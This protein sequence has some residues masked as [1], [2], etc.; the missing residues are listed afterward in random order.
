M[1]QP[2]LNLKCPF[3][4]NSC[5]VAARENSLFVWE[6]ILT[7]TLKGV[8]RIMTSSKRDDLSSLM[9]WLI[10]WIWQRLRCRVVNL[11]GLI[12]GGFLLMRSWVG[13]WW[14]LCGSKN[15]LYPQLLH[16]LGKFEITLLHSYLIQERSGCE[17]RN[18][19]KYELGCLLKDGL[20][21]LVSHVWHRENRGNFP[22]QR[23][24]NKIRRLRQFLRGLAKKHEGS[25][26]KEK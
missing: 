1:L 17:Y 20:I 22:M 9:R 11:V 4:L 6:T 18:S 5:N 21:E 13:C 23:W 16:L 12:L 26:N 3:W 24:Q 25:Y 10:V 7:Y 19:F 15:S 14:V 8:K 2:N